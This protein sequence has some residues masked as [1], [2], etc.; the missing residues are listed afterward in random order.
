[1]RTPGRIRRSDATRFTSS[2]SVYGPFSSLLRSVPGE[3][4]MRHQLYD[5][6]ILALLIRGSIVGR[7][8]VARRAG[9]HIDAWFPRVAL[10][11]YRVLVRGWKRT[12]RENEYR[13]QVLFETAGSLHSD[14]ER[15]SFVGSLGWPRNPCG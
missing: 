1:M 9:I 15:T 4:W 3:F 10:L 12:L 6:Y 5:R 11:E 14:L 2:Q 8:A 13:L 7:H